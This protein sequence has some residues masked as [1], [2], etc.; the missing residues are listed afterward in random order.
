MRITYLHQYFNTPSMPGSTRSYEMGRR[1]VAMGHEVNVVTSWRDSDGRKDWFTTDEAGMRVYWLPVPY[2]NH[3]SYNRRI[4]SFFKFAWGAARK[5]A[6]LPADVVFPTSTPLT[7]ALP[8]AYAARCQKVPMVFE[9]RDLWPDVP[10]AMGALTNPIMIRAS[11]LLEQFAIKNADAFVALFDRARDSLIAKG[12]R[13]DLIEVIPNGSDLQLFGAGNGQMIRQKLGCSPETNLILYAGAFGRVN[14]VSYIVDLANQLR[15]DARFKFL[16]IGDG[17]EKGTVLRQ[18]KEANLLGENLFFEDQ[19][20]KSAIVDYFAAADICMSTV[21]PLKILEGDSANKVFDGLAAGKLVA[22]NHGGQL[23][24][25]L[26]KTGAGVHLD[27]DFSV[28]ARQLQDYAD[29]PE[30]L[31]KAKIAARKLAE[32]Y[33]SRDKLA[34]KLEEVLLRTVAYSKA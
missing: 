13:N 33:F 32:D 34:I 4:A 17:F 11:L 24:N 8:G 2:S 25:L 28:A 27:H 14:G 12:V 22:T 19:V 31:T 30:R 9:V 15:R 7:I 10:I 26:E 1:L 3:M 29:Y 18:A 23:T 6:S 21:M 16:L 5:A 20:S